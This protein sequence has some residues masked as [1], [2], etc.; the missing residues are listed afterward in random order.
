MLRSLTKHGWRNHIAS[1]R[2]RAETGEVFAMTDLGLNLLEGIQ[3]RNGRSI[4][5][6]N[7]PCGGNVVS[8]GGGPRRP[9]CRVFIGLR[10]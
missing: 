1:L 4:V 8:P 10:I 7:P 6:R 9:Y 5:R 3:D 2:R